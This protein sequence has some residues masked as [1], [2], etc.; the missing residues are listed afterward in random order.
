MTSV[1]G[2]EIPDYLPA[3]VGG[4]VLLLVLQRVP[5]IG[6]A[7]RLLVSF[8]IIGVVAMLVLE[9]ASIDPVLAPLASRFNLDRQEVVGSEVRIRMASDGHFWANV[10][11][12]GA[13]RRMLI[14]SGATM[15]A[16]SERT[17]SAA[18]VSPEAEI[19]PVVLRTANGLVQAK[20]ARVPELRLGNIV[21]RDLKVVVSPAFGEM[22]VIGMN[23]LSKLKSWRVEEGTLVLVPHHPQPVSAD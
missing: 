18:D 14:D 3:V 22:D 2:T 11:M 8:A 7:I 19:V 5:V 15:T 23:F 12:N 16:I 13:K 21:A 20:T 17:A 4:V 6:G 10:S 9:R 1:F